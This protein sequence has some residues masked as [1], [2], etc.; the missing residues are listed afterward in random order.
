MGKFCMKCG[1]PVE[2]GYKFCLNCGAPTVP[3]APAK[4]PEAPAPAAEPEAPAVEAAP[5]VEEPVVEAPAEPKAY[6]VAASDLKDVVAL[7]DMI[8][9]KAAEGYCLI[10]AVPNGTSNKATLFFEKK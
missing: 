4:E 5:A 7:E 2:E 6:V 9:E 3:A 1:T 10:A 8:N